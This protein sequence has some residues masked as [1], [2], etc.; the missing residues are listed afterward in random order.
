MPAPSIRKAMNIVFSRPMWSETQPKNGRQSPFN[1]RSM[2][3]AGQGRQ[4]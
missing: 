3:S 1:T 4:G 2:E